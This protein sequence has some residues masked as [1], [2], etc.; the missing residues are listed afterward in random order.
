M[1]EVLRCNLLRCC[2]PRRI[3]CSQRFPS[4]PSHS[5]TSSKV[6]NHVLSFAGFTSAA[7]PSS[8]FASPSAGAGA[9]GT[10]AGAASGAAG[11]SS[12]FAVVGAVAGAGAAGAASVVSV[13]FVAASVVAVGFSSVFCF[14]SFLRKIPF[15]AFFRDSIGAVRKE[16]GQM[17]VCS[18]GCDCAEKGQLG[19]RTGVKVGLR[20]PK[21]VAGVV[22]ARRIARYI[23]RLAVCSS[24]KGTQLTNTRHLDRQ[25]SGSQGPI[26]K[27][28]RKLTPTQDRLLDSID[29]GMWAS[30]LLPN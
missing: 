21:D 23:G 20:A 5:S 13:G 24:E 1:C 30:G 22:A 19:D 15:R 6:E 26:T 25:I 2:F 18:W 17:L 14:F 28:T 16:G 8:F 7:G 4:P 3:E 9:A 10:A 29:L 11:V 12:V 27:T